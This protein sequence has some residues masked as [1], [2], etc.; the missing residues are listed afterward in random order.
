MA[1]YNT[2][3][4]TG[5]M[6]ASIRFAAER[7]RSEVRCASARTAINIE[8]LIFSVERRRRLRQH[9]QCTAS[10]VKP[11]C[12]QF[13]DISHIDRRGLNERRPQ[14]LTPSPLAQSWP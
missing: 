12:F 10:R 6:D 14:S 13:V 3:D 7:A 11:L 1:T 2:T 9:P 5:G 8:E 4:G